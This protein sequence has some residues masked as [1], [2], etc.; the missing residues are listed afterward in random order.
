MSAVP[1]QNEMYY[2]SL[3]TIGGQQ[4]HLNFDTGSA[5]LWVYAPSM[6][7]SGLTTF[8]PSKSSTWSNYQGAS[9]SISYGD[10]STAGGSVG[11]DTVNV[12]GAI[13]QKQC[14]ELADHASRTFLETP[15]SDGLLGLGFG[16][17]NQV[18]PQKQKT[19]FETIM[20]N[21]DQPVFTADLEE[22]A[23]GTYEF[24]SIDS[25]K[26]TGDIHYTPVDSSRGYWEFDSN[27]YS[28]GGAQKQCTRCN[29]GI[30]DTGTSLVLVDQDVADTYYRQ[31]QGATYSSLDGG[32]VY[33]CGSSLPDFGVA[34]G[35]YTAT[36]KGA[37]V[38]YAEVKGGCFGG[39][40]GTGSLDAGVQIYGDVLLKQFFA[41]FDG[42]NRRFG[43][44]QKSE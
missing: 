23:S 17:G 18:Y 26:Y 39:V 44:A 22:N 12:G 33:P 13:A 34:I 20:G 32:Y 36:I 3:V 6:A 29:N 19:F 5:D 16:N 27:S 30:A 43:I 25:S 11:Y 31:V 41:V 28:V 4:L 10:G 2:L 1:D 38:T 24:G 40:Q 42:G 9:W 21:L 37:D 7:S 35:D 14:V 15:D 8:D